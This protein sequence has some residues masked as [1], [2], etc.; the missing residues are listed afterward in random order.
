MKI[1]VKVVCT[2][3]TLPHFLGTVLFLVN[4]NMVPLMLPVIAGA[5]SLQISR[6]FFNSS[7]FLM[8]A[9]FAATKMSAPRVREESVSMER[10]SSPKSKVGVRERINTSSCAESLM[11]VDSSTARENKLASLL[12]LS[13]GRKTAVWQYH[14]ADVEWYYAKEQVMNSQLP[15]RDECT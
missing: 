7:P 1:R 14:L 12:N 10:R 3:H 5:P 6:R 15:Y 4:E 8:Q 9:F 11:S 13:A 2:F